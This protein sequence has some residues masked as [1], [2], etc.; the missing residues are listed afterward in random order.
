MDGTL[1]DPMD[2]YVASWNNGLKMSGVEKTLTKEDI[3]P[4]MGMEGRKVLEI[5]L[6][7]YDENERTE[8][9]KVINE[10]RRTLMEQGEG[11]LFDG[12]AEGLR[13]LSSRY[14]LFIV[15]N[16]PAGIIQ[17]F[18]KRAGI[19][20]YITDEMAYGVNFM[21]KHHNI[22]ILREK[23]D[24]LNPVYVGDTEGD[25]EQ[26]EKAGI[27]FVFISCGF[28]TVDKYD[29]AFDDFRSLTRYFMDLK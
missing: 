25:R 27:P 23:H 22:Q 24:L 4:L 7:E 2:L 15:S 5:T 17:V 12:M 29:Q 28:G 6:P 14:K 9:Y 8:I 18:M 1:W 3:K 13:E 19:E 26:S 11:T 10:Q 16:C 20:E 21:P